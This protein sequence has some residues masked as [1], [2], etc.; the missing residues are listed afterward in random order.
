MSN[1]TR[2]RTAGSTTTILGA[3]LFSGAGGMGLGA[4]QAG[5]KVVTAIESDNN[6]ATT[7]AKNHPHTDV[8]TKDI[9]QIKS[10][11]HMSSCQKVIFGGPPCQGFSTSN[12]RTRSSANASNWL[13]VEFLRLV[14]QWKPDWV[15]FENVRGILETEKASFVKRIVENLQD[16]GYTVSWW[17]LNAADFGV[18]QIRY[19]LFLIGSIAGITVKKPQ[20]ITGRHVTVAEAIA[21]LP[22]LPN[23]AA[24]N[25][26][27]YRCTP[28]SAYA[29]AMRGDLTTCSNHIVT[30]NADHILKRYK[31]IPMG[32]NWQN[33]PKELMSNY[34]DET[35]CHTGIYHRLSNDK[36][37]V[38]IG[39][40]RKNMLIHPRENRGLSVREAARLQSFPDW[41][42]FYGSIGFQQQQVGN[43]VPPLLAEH[44]F[45][46]IMAAGR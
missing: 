40:Y 46:A 36:P 32:G 15:V 21:D 33:I 42:E 30:R 38:V 29:K 7:Y 13:F 24:K 6:A 5:I 8:W 3:D 26:S 25:I 39:N 28:R 9:R 37:S 23:G 12:Q 41:Y 1:S 4:V 17:V 34:A 11:P 20:P 22:S 43:A 18:P 19:R 31:H 35:K 2:S 16:K 27:S 44:V 14:H 45:K 10:L